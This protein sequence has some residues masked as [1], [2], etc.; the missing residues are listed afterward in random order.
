MNGVYSPAHMY[1]FTHIEH[2]LHILKLNTRVHVMG[3]GGDVRDICTQVIL[4][5]VQ[6]SI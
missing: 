5:L 3:W 4:L 1:V 6:N 2:V